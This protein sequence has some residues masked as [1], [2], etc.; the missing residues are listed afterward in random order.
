[1]QQ[2]NNLDITKFVCAL[3]IVIIHASP[4]KNG[5]SMVNFYLRDVLAR[6]AVPLFFAISGFLFF[7]KLVYENG[8]IKKCPENRKRFI[9]YMKHII[10]LYVIWSA[11]YIVVSIPTWYK[12][13]WWGVALIKD[14]IVSFFMRGS[15]Y[16][17][18]YLLASIYAIPTLYFLMRYVSLR[19]LL[20]IMGLLWICECLSYSY[21]WIGI[22][23]I[24]LVMAISQKFPIAFDTFFRAL[25]L[26]AVGACCTFAKPPKSIKCYAVLTFLSFGLCAMEAS[27]L[28]FFTPNDGKYSYLFTTP[29]F[30][31]TALQLLV[32]GKQ[33]CISL[34]VSTALRNASLVI[35]CVHPLVIIFCNS[36]N[37]PG[38]VY[39]WS[40]TTGITV[41]FALVWSRLKL[42]VKR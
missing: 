36:M 10:F 38:G 27:L 19:K 1:M 31:Y 23:N 29:L 35:Y 32:N 41:C 16:H 21:S 2:L 14:I 22:E 40:L 7:R 30:S 11:V 42:A 4:L 26:I 37:V 13:G 9:K 28:Y 18:W 8:K 39:T 15:Y 12:M 25:P 6:I 34:K 20:H 5:S 33:A 24:S 3:L 17:L